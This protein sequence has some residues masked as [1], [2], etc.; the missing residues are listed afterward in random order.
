MRNYL[1]LDDYRN[2]FDEIWLKAYI[3]EYDETIHN[4]I[5]VKTYDEFVNWV[6]NNGLPDKVFF[7]HDLA[8]EHYDGILTD[9][10]TGY[11]AA[12]W[13]GNYCYD[14]S[15]NVPT[16]EIQSANPVGKDNIHNYLQFVNRAQK[17]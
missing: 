5:W 1:W 14:N 10:K 15:L 12:K 17:K 3:P 16:Y 6:S 9:E 13:L 4:I 2:P 11:D 8:H 7:D